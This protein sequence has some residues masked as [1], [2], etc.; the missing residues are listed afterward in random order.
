MFRPMLVGCAARFIVST[1]VGHHQIGIELERC[2]DA[3]V[4]RAQRGGVLS[5]NTFAFE[6]LT[7]DF[8]FAFLCSWLRNVFCIVQSCS[9]KLRL[10][11]FFLLYVCHLIVVFAL[12]S[13]HFHYFGL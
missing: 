1:M 6:I 9:C 12:G 8:A 5:C 3:L 7:S 10:N 2:N 4:Y 13:E 11:C